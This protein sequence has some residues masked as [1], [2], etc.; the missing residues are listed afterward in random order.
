MV[1]DTGSDSQKEV[2]LLGLCPVCE[3]DHAFTVY[4][5]DYN[6]DN[7]MIAM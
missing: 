5:A 2:N 6:C 3:L 1:I 7:E 4:C